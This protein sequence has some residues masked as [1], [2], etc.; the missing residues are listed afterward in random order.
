MIYGC[1]TI[2]KGNMISRQAWFL[3]LFNNSKIKNGL[4][5][6]LKSFGRLLAY[7]LNLSFNNSVLSEIIAHGSSYRFSKAVTVL[8]LIHLTFFVPTF[9]LCS[10]FSYSLEFYFFFCLTTEFQFFFEDIHFGY[11]L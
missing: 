10:L 3:M 9:F 6:N 2:T 8:F 7:I 4:S 5:F 11:T 1:I